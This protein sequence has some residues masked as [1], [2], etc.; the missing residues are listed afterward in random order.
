MDHADACRCK[1]CKLKGRLENATR[2]CIRCGESG[3]LA[4]P[5]RLCTDCRNYL[6]ILWCKKY[7]EKTT[8]S[9]TKNPHPVFHIKKFDAKQGNYKVSHHCG[10][11]EDQTMIT[12]CGM[13]AIEYKRSGKVKQFEVQTTV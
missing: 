10:C 13:H 12:Y 6:E 11:E 4:D 8:K 1:M 9:T 5:F 3:S 7:Y 2:V